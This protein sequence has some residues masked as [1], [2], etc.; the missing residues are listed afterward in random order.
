MA[1]A[2]FAQTGSDTLTGTGMVAVTTTATFS[3][4]TYLVES[5]SGTTD[6]QVGATG[7][8]SAGVLALD[9]GR[10]LQND[11]TFNWTGGSIAMGDNPLGTTVGGSTIVNSAGATF[12]DNVAGSITSSLGAN[13]FNNAG[14]FATNFSGTN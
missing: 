10:K 11:G 7:T 8:L 3:G 5:G 2:G 12:N 9:G 13:Q 14:T 1:V 4:A 6:L